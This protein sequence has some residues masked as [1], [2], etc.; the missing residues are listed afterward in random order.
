[1]WRRLS[2]DILAY[3][4]G[5]VAFRWLDFYNVGAIEG[6]QPCA[7]RGRKALAGVYDLSAFIWFILCHSADIRAIGCGSS[8]GI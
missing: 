3:I 2:G 4:A 7:V 6:E 8:K 1:M 5:A